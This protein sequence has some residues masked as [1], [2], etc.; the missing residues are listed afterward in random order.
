MSDFTVPSYR[1]RRERTGFQ[2]PWRMVAL[3]GAALG[4]AGVGGGI[5]WGISRA[6]NHTVPVI[7][8]DTRPIRVKPSDPGGMRVANQDERIF[9][10]QRRGATGTA[11]QPRLSPEPERPDV[12]ALRQAAARPPAVVVLP[13]SQP[14]A[15]PSRPPL[16]NPSLGPQAPAAP[17]ALVPQNG[18]SQPV[19]A[20]APAT[21]P[22]PAAAPQPAA[23]PLVP[24]QPAAVQAPS[25]PPAPQAAAAAQAT[26]AIT[27][28]PMPANS[29]TPRTGRVVVQL[30]ALGSEEAARNEWPKLQARLPQLAGREPQ[31]TR[32]D[33]G[34]LPPLWRIRATNMPDLAAART[35]C[36]SA[37]TKNL[38]CAVLGG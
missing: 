16:V 31:I 5:V 17:Q 37:K 9:E 28:P 23:S 18:T 35:L 1:V 3:A 36:E 11:A 21:V 14:E 38:P 12:A 7:E 8:A 30:G 6:V 27:P 32:V 24:P 22:S 26:P 15:A 29:P 19:P 34:D 13:A 25:Q 20:A 10:S 2:I 4:A 33:R